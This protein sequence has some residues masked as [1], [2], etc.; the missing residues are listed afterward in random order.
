[1]TI[2][3]GL[4]SGLPDR[5][6]SRRDLL[7]ISGIASC[8]LALGLAGCTPRQT[9]FAPSGTQPLPPPPPLA[10]SQ[11]TGSTRRFAPTTVGES[12]LITGRPDGLPQRHHT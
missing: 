8:G 5:G 2:E 1:M 12:Q 4:L 9:T 3:R 6:P 11:I 7:I 10:P